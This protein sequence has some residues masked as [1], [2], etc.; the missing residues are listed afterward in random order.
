MHSSALIVCVRYRG[1]SRAVADFPAVRIED[2]CVALGIERA[3]IGRQRASHL[4]SIGPLGGIDQQS[5]LIAEFHDR[6][7]DCPAIVS[8]IST[9]RFNDSLQHQVLG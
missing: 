3:I 8:R 1:L 5:I 6:T 2:D 7:R 4:V 9:H